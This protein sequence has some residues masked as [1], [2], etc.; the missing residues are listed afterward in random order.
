MQST[1]IIWI[2]I[3]IQIAKHSM[4]KR[5]IMLNIRIDLFKWFDFQ[6]YQ[7][8]R[9][10][11]KYN[12]Q[13]LSKLARLFLRLLCE[14]DVKRII[15]LSIEFHVCISPCGLHISHHPSK[16]STSPTGSLYMTDRLIAY[17]SFLINTSTSN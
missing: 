3:P 5:C 2:D 15:V 6:Y 16:M 10:Y 12:I 11:Q 17:L 7:L 4:Y 13:L 1:W 8:P 14:L 9:V